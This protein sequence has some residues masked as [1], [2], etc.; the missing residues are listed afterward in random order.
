MN[1]RTVSTRFSNK[2]NTVR[3]KQSRQFIVCLCLCIYIYMCVCVCVCVRTHARVVIDSTVDN[4]YNIVYFI[5]FIG[6][7]QMEHI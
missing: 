5:M 6:L 7:Q 3:H 4:I 2:T 1:K